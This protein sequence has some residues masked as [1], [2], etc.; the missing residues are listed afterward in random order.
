MTCN[1]IVLPDLT[2]K[3]VAHEVRQVYCPISFVPVLDQAH[4]HP[5]PI[6][7]RC[8]VMNR[9]LVLDTSHYNAVYALRENGRVVQTGTLALPLVPAGGQAEIDF[10]PEW[11]KIPGATYH[12][13]ISLCYNRDMPFAPAGYELGC[14]QFGLPSEA[15]ESEHFASSGTGSRVVTNE[16]VLILDE[17]ADQLVIRGDSF[18]VIF[19]KQAG[20]IR[21][22]IRGETACPVSGPVPCFERPWSGLDADPGWGCR[23][24]WQIADSR[25]MLLTLT[26]WRAERLGQSRAVIETRHQVTFSSLSGYS[27]VKTR[28]VINSDGSIE[29]DTRFLMDENLCHLP[30]IGVTWVIPEGFEQLTYWGLGPGENYR[31]RRQSARLGV[32]TGSVE[33]EHFPFIP[34]SENGGHEETRWLELQNGKGQMI[35]F[36]LDMPGHFDIHHHTVTD[37]KEARHEHELIRRPESFLHL[38][39]AHSGIG[40]DMGWSTVLNEQDRVMAKSCR[41]ACTIQVI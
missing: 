39:A 35:R 11:E 5:L 26:G 18:S 36:D 34:P 12:M 32:F 37:Y 23:E 3:P 27:F 9:H 15:A 24:L 13:D 7:G 8:L 22:I 10:S 28:F 40:S 16:P 14:W 6:P 19:D 17:K 20:Q 30:R 1:G 29:V 21:S 31:D 25:Q 4:R 41:L 2:L 33:Q 38:D